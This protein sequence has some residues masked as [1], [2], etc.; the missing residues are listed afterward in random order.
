MSVVNL[1]GHLWKRRGGAGEWRRFLLLRASS[2]SNDTGT[3]HEKAPLDASST[4]LRA[5]RRAAAAC[6]WVS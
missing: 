6:A 5:S 1:V 4:A 3:F 2:R